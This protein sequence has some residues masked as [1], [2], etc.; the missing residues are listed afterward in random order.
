MSSPAFPSLQAQDNAP[1]PSFPAASTHAPTFSQMTNPVPNP[2]YPAAP[3]QVPVS[4]PNPGAYIAPAVPTASPI[5][6]PG[7]IVMPA[8]SVYA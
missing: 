2:S 6:P 3:S 5:T 7:Y 1:T 4:S 8:D